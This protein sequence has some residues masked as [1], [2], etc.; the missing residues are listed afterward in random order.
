MR[1]ALAA[2]RVSGV[3]PAALRS[4]GA[5]F[6]GCG[7][8][9]VVPS[10]AELTRNAVRDLVAAAANWELVGPPPS[11]NLVGLGEPDPAATYR[12]TFVSRYDLPDLGMV[13]IPLLVAMGAGIGGGDGPNNG[14]AAQ[15]I[16]REPEL[17]AASIVTGG[18]WTMFF[19]NGEWGGWQY[20]RQS[21]RPGWSWCWECDRAVPQPRPPRRW[22]DVCLADPA[23][24][25]DR[26]RY[27]ARLAAGA[28][29]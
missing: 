18:F 19:R 12:R 29:V 20:W 14:A 16:Q 15:V 26:A 2:G 5:L 7:D 11:D 9:G 17:V 1:V 24:R 6:T 8:N 27:F 22:C 23:V 3:V 21:L 10:R 13:E 4:P 25:A 28:V